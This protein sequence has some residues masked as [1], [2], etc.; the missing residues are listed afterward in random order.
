MDLKNKKI[1]ITGGATRL[2]ET[3]SRALAK[4]G[5]HVFIHYNSSQKKA[6][7]LSKELKAP[8]FQADLSRTEDIKK[9]FTE[10][11][12]KTK[13]LD[14]LINN[15]AI[16]YPVPFLK[17]TEK[18]WNEFMDTNL[19]SVFFCSQ[20]AVH[21]MKKNLESVIINI[22]DVGGYIM[23]KDYLAYCTSKAGVLAL[24]KG[25]AKTLAPKIRVNTVAPGPLL[26]PE[27]YS[28]KHSASLTLLKKIGSPQ[29]LI[30]AVQ[31]LIEN[32]FLTGQVIH[33]DGG[34]FI[35]DELID[36]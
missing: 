7:K 33:L 36:I 11:R 31:F 29:K 26:L 17:T 8:C 28:K 35:N 24:T 30:H 23:W 21:L 12:K 15:A 22:A 5:A 4:K 20:E 16:F 3:L 6:L 13:K 32:D 19:R 27:G 25:L 14:I 18:Q 1:L 9:L 34:R 10:V 2:G